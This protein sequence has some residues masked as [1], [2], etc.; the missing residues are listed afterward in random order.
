M[1]HQL[2]VVVDAVRYVVKYGVQWRA[3]PADYPDY[4]DWQAV[5][6]FCERW[7][8]QP[9]GPVAGPAVRPGGPGGAAG[10]CGDRFPVRPGRVHGR[11][12]DQRF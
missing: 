8:A 1:D 9:G 5:Y 6:A 10:R 2:R 12:C 4:P 7:N 11:G 3:R